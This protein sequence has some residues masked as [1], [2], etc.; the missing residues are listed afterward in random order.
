MILIGYSK[1]HIFSGF[2]TFNYTLLVSSVYLL[3]QALSQKNEK[4][5]IPIFLL[6]ATIFWIIIIII[7][8]GLYPMF[9]SPDVQGWF[10]ESKLYLNY[11]ITIFIT[12]I[13]SL[14]LNMPHIESNIQFAAASEKIDESKGEKSKTQDY[15]KIIEQEG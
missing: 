6:L 12:I 14:F 5:K 1:S 4:M 7:L 9:L 11:L 10:T 13:I 3:L 2:L 15:K 8:Y